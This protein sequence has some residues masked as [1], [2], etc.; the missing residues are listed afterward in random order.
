MNVDR[1]IRRPEL[2]K[3]TGLS[4]ATLYRLMAE[5]RF[6]RPVQLSQN[7]VG[8]RAS[9]VFSWVES[10]KVAGQGVEPETG[11]RPATSTRSRSPR[12]GGA[13]GHARR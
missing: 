2:L 10:L 7:A 11:E 9:A 13:S 4:S 6:P 1:I 8:W 3:V 12:R 5:E